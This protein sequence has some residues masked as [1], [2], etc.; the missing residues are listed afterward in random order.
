MEIR[1]CPQ[2]YVNGCLAGMLLVRCLMDV[3]G[4]IVKGHPQ[5][6]GSE[7]NAASLVIWT[8]FLSLRNSY[9]WCRKSWISL[10]DGGISSHTPKAAVILP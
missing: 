4:L 1:G 6:K 8:A 3:S 7:Y 10:R 9:S 5:R 2:K